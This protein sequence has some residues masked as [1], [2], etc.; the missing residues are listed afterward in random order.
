MSTIVCKRNDNK[1]FY[2][3]DHLIKTISLPDYIER[4]TDTILRWRKSNLSA[5]CHCPMPNHNDRNASFHIT[6]MPNGAWIYHCFGCGSKG[7]LVHFCMD[8]HGLS[9]KSESILYIC[10]KFNIK[11]K[12]DIILQGIKN[13]GKRVDLQRKMENSN[14]I[15]SNQCRLLLRKN[16]AVHK[17]WVSETYK[18]LDD[19]LDKEDYEMLE[20]IQYEALNRMSEVIPE[21]KKNEQTV[22]G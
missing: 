15:A 17:D 21:E 16:F 2:L 5:A 18:R 3:V 1:L 11:D 6:Q 19:A 10:K 22:V 8:Y 7:H 9:N 4:E 13:V 12:E 20:G 14:I